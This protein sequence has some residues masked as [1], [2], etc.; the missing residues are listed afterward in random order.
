MLAEMGIAPVLQGLGTALIQAIGALVRYAIG[1]SKRRQR[2]RPRWGALQSRMNPYSL[3]N[4]LNVLAAMEIWQGPY[5]G[6]TVMTLLLAQGITV[7]KSLEYTFIFAIVG[8]WGPK[9][10]GLRL[11]AIAR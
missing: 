3:L 1:M 6:R 7:T 4:A 10:S 2:R 11:E 8:F 5:F 9:T